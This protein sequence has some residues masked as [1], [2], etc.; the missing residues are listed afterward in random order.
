VQ[1]Q[2]VGHMFR[3]TCGID[4]HHAFARYEWELTGPDGAVALTG[5]DFA[6]VGEDGVLRRVVGILG[7]I[8]SKDA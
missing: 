7:P 8:P 3:R 1:S 5:V 4:A 6:Q 2:F